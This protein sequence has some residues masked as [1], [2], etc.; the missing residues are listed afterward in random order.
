M[1]RSKR[2]ARKG[3]FEADG[4]NGLSSFLALVSCGMGWGGGRGLPGNEFYV[5]GAQCV[6]QTLCEAHWFSLF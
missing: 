5:D 2:G 4:H 3:N 6:K 1:N